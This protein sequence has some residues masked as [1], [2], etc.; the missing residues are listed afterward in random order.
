MERG[1]SEDQ[2]DI[3]EHVKFAQLQH[4]EPHIEGLVDFYLHLLEIESSHQF[5]DDADVLALGF[6][7]ELLTLLDRSPVECRSALT[8]SRTFPVEVVIH[9]LEQLLHLKL[10]GGT[11][12]LVFFAM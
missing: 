8:G 10:G 11:H 7:R 6:V 3:L 4:S 2:F 5:I 9:Q 12:R 1:I